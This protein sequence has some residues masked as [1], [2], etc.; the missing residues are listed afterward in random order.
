MSKAV[1]LAQLQEWPA[2]VVVTT[3][4]RREELHRCLASVMTQSVPLQILVFD[5]GSSDGTAEM[6]RTEF[7]QVE[8]SRFEAHSGYIVQRN[9]AAAM[10]KAPVVFSLDDDAVLST[11]RVVEQTLRE[12]D[13]P[14]VGAVAVPFVNVNT[15]P[16]VRQRAP[17]D[18]QIYA[19]YAYVGTAH[20]LRRDL[21]L[22]LGGYRELLVHQTE[23]EDYSIRMLNAG[24]V[25][26][27]GRAD[28]IHHFESPRRNWSRMDFYSAAN[29][30]M[31]AWNN[32][33]FPYFPLHLAATSVFTSFQTRKPDRA[34]TRWR[35]VADAYARCLTGRA[36][37]RPV[38][39]AAYRLSRLLK[40]R[41]AVPLAEI[42]ARLP[43]IVVR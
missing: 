9:R 21:F 35:G 3:K 30:V 20:A 24:H 13:H 8:F 25:V 4:D 38:S 18:A 2:T 14:R 29:K 42:E 17:D 15:S 19:T 28:V 31:Y 22:R 11:P 43:G 34:L 12:F 27:C 36:D 32:V 41:E 16:E 39:A 40:R 26:R 37:R 1:S 33:P 10:A 6:V 5:D 23:E 7:P